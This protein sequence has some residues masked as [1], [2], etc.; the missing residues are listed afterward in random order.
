MGLDYCGNQGQETEYTEWLKEQMDSD[1]LASKEFGQ[2]GPKPA[3]V[4]DVLDGLEQFIGGD[5]MPTGTYELLIDGHLRADLDPDQILP[6]LVTDL[7]EAEA[8]KVLATLDPL[9]AMADVDSDALARLIADAAPP[10]DLAAMFPDVDLAGILAPEPEALTDPDD[11]PELPSEPVSQR[12]DVWILGR[13][14]LMCGDSTEAVD[15]ERLLGGAKVDSILTDPPYS[16][17]GF[18]ESGRSAGSKATTAAYKAIPNDRLS[19]R[20]YQ[21]LIKGTLALV[22][23]SVVYVFTDWRMWVNLFDVVESSGYGVRSMIVWNKEFPGMGM[24]WRSQHELIMCGTRENG[25]WLKHMGAQGNV[26]TLKRDPNL[27]HP[28]MKPVALLE[29]VLETTP[30]A[31]TVYDPFVG[32]GTTIIAAERQGR[33]CWAMELEPRYV[34]SSVKRW[35]DYTGSKAHRE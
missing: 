27:E 10:V 21:A 11:V 20:G 17:G 23:V 25:M 5:T 12:G 7:D 26:I 9:A 30:F 34:D 2:S 18:Q 1:W 16:S 6:V 15:V 35:E 32:S 29:T 4:F 14:R 33:A 8:G 19:T 24:G 31:E 13:H 3:T 22:P 28:T